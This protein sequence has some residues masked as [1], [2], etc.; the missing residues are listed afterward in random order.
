MTLPQKA[1]RGLA[2]GNLA[3]MAD[4]VVAQ[5]SAPDGPLHRIA[6]PPKLGP[7]R[8]TVREAG[9]FFITMGV[10]VLLFVAYQ[11]FGTNFAEQHSQAVLSKQFAASVAGRKTPISSTSI[12]GSSPSTTSGQA[13]VTKQAAT[14]GSPSLPSVP[15]GQAIDHLVIPAIGVDKFVVQGT[16]EADL[17]EGPGHYPGTPL[18]GQDGNVAIAG[19]RTTFGAPFFRLGDLAVGDSIYITDLSDHTWLYKVSRANVVVSPTDVAVLDSTPFPQLTL[20]TCNPIFSAT[21]RLVV[22]AHLVGRALPVTRPTTT[23]V[24]QLASGRPAATPVASNLAA[25]SPVRSGAV[26]GFDA[27]G[28]TSK[29]WAPA[30]EYGVAVLV[31]WLGTRIWINRTRRWNRL[32]AYVVGVGVCLIPLWFCFENATRLLPPSV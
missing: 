20:T 17:S 3:N 14:P 4:A 13:T 27:G 6:A 24:T 7:I 28:G 25:A 5:I 22:F 19:H 1:L 26:T 15:S 9:L 18:P 8:R 23:K 12:P 10:I 31:L 16:N 32:V 11:L 21:S 29:A 2:R 30:L